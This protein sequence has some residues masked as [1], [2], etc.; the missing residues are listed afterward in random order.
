MQIFHKTSK[1]V[2]NK[3]FHHDDC[4]TTLLQWAA[5][6]CDKSTML[7]LLQLGADIMQADSLHRLPLEVA[8]HNN[9]SKSSVSLLLTEQQ[10]FFQGGILLFKSI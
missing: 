6:N 3:L 8:I 9:N 7:M 5:A 10:V 1:E 2:V 4:T